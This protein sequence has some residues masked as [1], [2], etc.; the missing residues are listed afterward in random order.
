MDFYDMQLQKWKKENLSEIK[1]L[2]FRSTC[3]ISSVSNITKHNDGI[4]L[5]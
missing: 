1:S 3:T 5:N 2:G 4:L